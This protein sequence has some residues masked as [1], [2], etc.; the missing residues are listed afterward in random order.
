MGLMLSPGIFLG[1]TGEALGILGGY[2][3]PFDHSRQLKSGLAPH[4]PPPP[5]PW[6]TLQVNKHN[7]VYLSLGLM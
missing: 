5:L 6:K 1:F 2:M 4:P 7:I 3:P